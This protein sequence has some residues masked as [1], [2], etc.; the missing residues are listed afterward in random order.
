MKYAKEFGYAGQMLPILIT[1]MIIH[2]TWTY[3]GIIL[4][5]I[6]P[7]HITYS[8]TYISVETGDMHR[9]W[10]WQWQYCW[11][12]Q[13]LCSPSCRQ[14]WGTPHWYGQLRSSQMPYSSW[15][16][17]NIN[18]T[19]ECFTI[20][21]SKLSNRVLEW[22]TPKS[23]SINSVTIWLK[24]LDFC[25]NRCKWEFPDQ[26]NAYYILPPELLFNILII[27]TVCSHDI[28]RA[29]LVL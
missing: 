26:H 20:T 5:M 1:Y 14:I 19:L 22:L 28:Y 25:L 27:S 4:S 29:M 18:K 7:I 23:T 17:W 16:I 11:G 13:L 3:W 24:Q 6:N 9:Y 10:Q 15:C 21:D 12:K 8:P 2:H